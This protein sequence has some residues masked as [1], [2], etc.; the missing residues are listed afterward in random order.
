M[1]AI[2][3]ALPGQLGTPG[4]RMSISELPSGDTIAGNAANWPMQLPNTGSQS[5][6]DVNIP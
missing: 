3:G 6:T 4:N 5:A 2:S 1:T